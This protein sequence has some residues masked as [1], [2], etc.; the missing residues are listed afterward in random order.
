AAH[1][2]E[3]VFD[4]MPERRARPQTMTK[5][6][7]AP[8]TLVAHLK[9]AAQCKLAFDANVDL[10]GADLRP[11]QS[12][13]KP[14]GQRLELS[15]KGTRSSSGTTAN[16]QQRIELEAVALHVLDDRI[17]AHGWAERKGAGDKAT[18]QFERPV[19]REHL[20]LDR[21]LLVQ[22]PPPEEKPPPDPKTFAGLSGH[23]TA[24]LA[25]VTYKKQQF[26]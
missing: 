14:P 1:A 25:R 11:G 9:G 22:K 5:A 19:T 4:R 18:K 12:L 7:G 21:R 3:G 26:Q 13:D 24:K 10:A 23:A 6:A 8:M 2:L 20:D 17:D 15:A 16:P